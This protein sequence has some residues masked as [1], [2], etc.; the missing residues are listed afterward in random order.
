M[1][2]RPRSLTVFGHTWGAPCRL[3]ILSPQRRFLAPDP[4]GTLLRSFPTGTTSA[5]DLFATVGNDA[6]Y[7]QG[8]KF[9]TG[10]L[11]PIVL[12][13]YAESDSYSAC[14]FSCSPQPRD[15]LIYLDHRF[16]DP[17]TGM[18]LS[19]DPAESITDTP[20]AYATDDPVNVFDPKG[21]L[22]VLSGH[23]GLEPGA[24]TTTVP[25][26]ACVNFYCG[27]GETITNGQSWPIEQGNPPPPFESFGPG[28]QVPNYTLY[29]PDENISTVGNPETVTSPTK[30][31]TLMEENG[32]TY[33][34]AAC[35]SGG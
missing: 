9:F 31:S 13:G 34:W 35:R 12:H 16:L 20:Y 2:R 25:P 15:S 33:D 14:F 24:G 10:F 5:G 11:T 4:N 17:N 28:E 8:P 21:L 6:G 23:G 22:P 32:G 3:G 1:Y 30:L 26:G 19:V 7:G 27:P 29:P 18:F